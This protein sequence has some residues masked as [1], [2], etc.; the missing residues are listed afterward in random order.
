MK[1][2]ELCPEAVVLLSAR[3]ASDAVT[4]RGVKRGMSG[5]IGWDE[6]MDIKD[7]GPTRRD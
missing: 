1:M 7:Q 4:M 3:P 5:G 6:E 2:E